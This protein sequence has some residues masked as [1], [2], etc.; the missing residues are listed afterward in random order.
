M[1]INNSHSDPALAGEESHH[2]TPRRS[3]Q[4]KESHYAK[5]LWIFH[6]SIFPIIILFAL[7]IRLYGINWDQGHHLHPDER[8]LTMVTAD[9]RIP[10]SLRDYLD[11][12]VST[13]N[14]YNI[15]YSFYVYG[16][17][18]VTL[19]KLIA[20]SFNRD[21]YAGTLITGRVLSAVADTLTLVWIMAIAVI[22]RKRYSL[23]AYVPHFTGLMY[24]MA[25]LPIQNAHFFTVDSLVVMFSIGT[26]YMILRYI[27]QNKLR[28]AV[29]GGLFFGFALASKISAMYISPL[30]GLLMAYTV[31]RARTQ[32][33]VVQLFTSVVVFGFVAFIVL[34]I[35]SPHYFSSG[36]WFDI[37]ISK[38]FIA[39][40]L[41]LKSF[42]S[43]ES[44][45]FPPSVQWY[46][47]KPFLFATTNVL[48]FGLGLPYAMLV[49]YGFCALA[50]EKKKILNIIAL[51]CVGYFVY[52]SIQFAA[53]MRYLYVLYPFFALYAGFGFVNLIGRIRPLYKRTVGAF[54]LLIVFIWP[55]SFMAI[56]TRPH[57]RVS[58]SDWIFKNIPVGSFIATE[59]W[60][61]PLPLMLGPESATYAYGGEQLPVFG[62]D[63]DLKWQEMN[64]I[65]AKSDYY[66]LSSNRGYDSILPSPEK[67]PL[68][69]QFYKD[70]FAGKTDFIQVAEFTSYPTIPLIG[71]KIDDQWSEEAFTVY[72]HPKVGIF[73]N[74]SKNS[75]AQ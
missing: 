44:G 69:T 24:A 58:A 11:P 39:N 73:K 21:S 55:L 43:P 23:P 14:P 7:C 15:K 30:L 16:T 66:I 35:G 65:L 38:S 34:R 56:Y 63:D 71:Y 45:Y 60:D 19:N 1:N 8:F 5:M 57:S 64:R 2:S 50:I 28:F 36:S 61:D 52:Q 70:L 27:E 40:I 54:V 67:Y 68:M 6:K 33:S 26:I 48:F 51:W 20:H 59:H 13:L 49:I 72:D 25:V 46:S 75:A 37:S 17:L 47:K 4:N 29:F 12:S 9:S 31:Y 62:V 74:T 32:K 41:Q 42:T 10:E 22:L 18:P 3:E 53:S